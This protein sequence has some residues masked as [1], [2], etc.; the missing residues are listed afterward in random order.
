[1]SKTPAVRKPIAL[2]IAVVGAP[3]H[4]AREIL[5]M[6]EERALPVASAVALGTGRGVGQPISFGEDRVLKT[7]D[8]EKFDFAG[9]NLAFFAADA[10]V[11]RAHAPRAAAAGCLV[12]DLSTAFR[13]ELDV[14]LLVPEVNPAALARAT[15]RRIISS[16]D[17]LV[18]QL[19]L[20]LKPLMAL[21]KIL[22]VAACSYESTSG[23]SKAAMDELWSQARGVYVNEVPPAEQFPKQIA[24][25]VIPQVDSF[26]GDGST[27]AEQRMAQEPRKL[28]DPDLLVAATCVRVPTF[29]G[30]GLALNIAFEGPVT[31]RQARDALRDAPGLTLLDRREEGSYATPLDV[32][33]EDQVMVGRIRRD[34]TLPHG[35]HA[36]V[37]GDNL[38][39]GTA[40]NA[41]Q[42]AEEALAARLIG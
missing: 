18:V 32:A 14:P 17:P 19:A 29:V 16:P 3:G 34:P 20:V 42:I 25:N 27:L 41:V 30:H 33:G 35:L 40:M 38:R 7:Q 2:T 8:L 11:A 36:W 37:M 23:A 39:K 31:E 21:S 4:I 15:K 12:I 5:R 22:R 26:A 6:V 1:M 9:V 24:F 13:M 28:L 10:A